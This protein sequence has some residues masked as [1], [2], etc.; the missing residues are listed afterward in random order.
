MSKM[1]AK[2]IIFV[3]ILVL[4]AGFA[5]Y[6]GESS[7]LASNGVKL[8]KPSGVTEGK[9]VL[10]GSTNNS[11]IKLLVSD[12]QAQTWY[13]VA[14]YNGGFREEIWLSKEA[15][16][17]ISI[18][19]HEYDR[20]YSY[21]PSISV[22]NTK[23]QNKYLIPAKHIESSD[24][25]IIR[26]SRELTEGCSTDAEKAKAIYDWIVDNIQF[27][28]AK[29]AKHQE[30]NYDNSY[31]AQNTLKTGKGV[32]YDFATLY[33]ALGRAA[34]L[35]TKVAE[36]RLDTGELAGFHAWNEVYAREEERWILLDSTMEATTGEEYFDFENNDEKYTV[37]NYK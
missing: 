32:C 27:D 10:E 31:G 37:Q 8:Q 24:D 23:M 28:Y 7:Y 21:G 12:G 26:L 2:V 34:G 11:K 36:G 5:V 18:M 15:T 6:A 9:V 17:T 4:A 3:M 22:K 1:V 14:I 19:V 35:Q 29:Y 13:D 25:D 20:K 16:Y 30:G 33:A